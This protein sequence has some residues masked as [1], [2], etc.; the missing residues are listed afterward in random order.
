M[1]TIRLSAI[2]PATSALLAYAPPSQAATLIEDNF[3][4]L[5]TGAYLNGR[6]PGISL[7]GGAW[8]SNTTDAT[9][10]FRGN[11]SGGLTVTIGT[12]RTVSIDLGANYFTTNPGVYDLSVDMTFPSVSSE[13]WIAL[14]FS[15][16]ATVNADASANSN[17]SGPWF[18]YRLNGQI[19]V[20]AG[21]NNTNSLTNTGANPTLSATPNTL[22]SLTIRLDTSAPQ[23]AF[24]ILLDGNAVDLGSTGNTTYT[25]SPGN[26]PAL[27]HLVLSTGGGSTSSTA[28]LDNFSFVSVPEPGVTFLT[29]LSA[30]TLLF[31]RRRV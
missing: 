13:S 11:G 17:T 23:W 19:E 4:N 28:T 10:R 26:N 5:A 14:G 18:V 2:L 16:I 3:D 20:F 6:I 1:R 9:T 12:A 29:G 15:S 8:K 30:L 25:Y 22:H 21:Q 24:Q 31:N 7:A 27:R